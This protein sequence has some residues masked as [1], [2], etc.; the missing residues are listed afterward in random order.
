MKKRLVI[1][2]RTISFDSTQC[3]LPFIRG[4]Y[5]SIV[6]KEV[7]YAAGVAVTCA[8]CDD[9]YKLLTTKKRTLK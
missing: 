3:L 5:Y 4:A 7:Y 8:D 6:Y 2:I 9:K 1:Q